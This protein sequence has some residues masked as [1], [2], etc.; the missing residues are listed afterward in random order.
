[1]ITSEIMPAISTSDLPLWN[2]LSS[3]VKFLM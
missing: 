2:L 3:H 1:M